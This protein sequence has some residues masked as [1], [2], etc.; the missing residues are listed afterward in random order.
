MLTVLLKSTGAMFCIHFPTMTSSPHPP[1]QLSVDSYRDKIL[2]C[3]MGKS[4]GGT[5]GTP[6]E[7]MWGDRQPFDI[8][9]YP[10]IREGGLPNDDLELQL[11][12]LIAL[13]ERGLDLTSR[14]LAEYWLDYIRY[15]PDEYGLHKTNLRLGLIPPVSG[16][17][18][19]PFRDCMGCPIRSEIWACIAPGL[20]DVAAAYAWRDAIVDHACGESVYGEVSNAALQSAAFFISDRDHLLDISLSAIPDDCMTA[21]TIRRARE[22]H[23]RGL[24]WLDARN[25]VMEFAYHPN[26]QHSPINLGFQTI[27]WLYGEEFGDHLCKAVNCGWDTDCTGATLGA[28]LGLIHGAA[29]LPEKWMA[30]LGRS[31]ATSEE[32]GGITPGPLPRTVD[33]LTERTMAIGRQL[34]ARY[35]DRVT[36]AETARTPEASQLRTMVD[37]GNVRDTLARRQDGNTF[38]LYAIEVTIAYPEGPVIGV[39]RAARIQIELKSRVSV[40]VEGECVLE[41]PED[42]KA[43]GE[44]P[45]AF[46][47]NPGQTSGFEFSVKTASPASIQVTNTI[48]LK[49]RL[50]RRPTPEALPIILIGARRWLVSDLNAERTLEDIEGPPSASASPPEGWTVMNF[51]DNELP[52]ERFFAGQ[53]GVVWLQHW[54]RSPEAGT[55]RLGVPTDGRMKLWIDGVERHATTRRVPLRPSL[56][57]DEANYVDLPLS[58][59]WHQVVIALERDSTP[60][61]A[62]FTV[63]CDPPL[64]HGMDQLE[65]TRFPWECESG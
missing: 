3:W 43:E 57:G 61:Q 41:L 39:D 20:P 27:G 17:Y 51:P 32:I 6:L 59:G 13:E 23:A 33:E 1:L 35:G 36:L 5:L 19:N 38:V 53:A 4:A 49:L 25:D 50:H 2:G 31:I 40:P 47:L 60:I 42:F 58:A 54:L 18:N 37:L 34:L 48:W 44:F 62:H 14:D 21:R 52:V 46:S 56:G 12:W 16:A 7:K 22:A 29:S 63:A 9:F 64:W 24:S 30:P 10:V 28:T 8:D 26:G 11:I 65:Q 15:N 55:V 45:V